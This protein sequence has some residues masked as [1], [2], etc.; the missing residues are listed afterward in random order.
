MNIALEEPATLTCMWERRRRAQ[1]KFYYL[2]PCLR[3]EAIT[4]LGGAAAVSEMV[5][6]DASIS[7]IRRRAATHCVV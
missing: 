5:G 1:P 4:C 3:I 2:L 6:E 7:D